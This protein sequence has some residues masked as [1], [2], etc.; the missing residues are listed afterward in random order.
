MTKEYA[1][2]SQGYYEKED[3]YLVAQ[4]VHQEAKGT[5]QEGQTAVAN[6]VYNRIR[7][8]RY[9]NTIETVVFQDGQFSP[10]DNEDKLR[11]VR[12]GRRAIEAVL[13]IFVRGETILPRDVLY[14]RAARLGTT[15]SS[16]RR[17]YDTYGGNCFFK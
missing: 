11:S 15:W 5:S 2:F 17:Y 6:V 13:Q 12:P 14:F 8:R 7:S 9:P 16:A 1:E 10:A 3:L 4:L